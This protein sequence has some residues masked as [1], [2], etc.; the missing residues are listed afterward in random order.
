MGL[1]IILNHISAAL[2]SIKSFCR[3]KIWE[4]RLSITS[5]RDF[6]SEIPMTAFNTQSSS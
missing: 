3:E 4:C 2:S 1:D 5:S 6:P